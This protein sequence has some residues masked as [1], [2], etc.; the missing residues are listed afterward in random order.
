MSLEDAALA[1][2]ILTKGGINGKII[3]EVNS[4]M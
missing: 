2:D 4:Q 1:Q 3:L